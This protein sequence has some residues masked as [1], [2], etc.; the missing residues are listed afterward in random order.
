MKV[1][2]QKYELLN[3]FSCVINYKICCYKSFSIVKVLSMRMLRNKLLVAMELSIS[4][5]KKKKNNLKF[6][7]IPKELFMHHPP[8]ISK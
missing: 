1:Q 6:L 8:E 4:F 5:Y 7:F 2:S 3:G